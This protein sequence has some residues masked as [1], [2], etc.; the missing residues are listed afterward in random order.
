MSHGPKHAE[1]PIPPGILSGAT[2]FMWTV[3]ALEAVALVFAL[4]VYYR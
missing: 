1:R 3:A 4:M 2:N